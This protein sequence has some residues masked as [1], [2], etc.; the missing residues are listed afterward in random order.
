M[1][2]ADRDHRLNYS[3]RS[4]KGKDVVTLTLKA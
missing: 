2:G 3:P 4:L 1:A